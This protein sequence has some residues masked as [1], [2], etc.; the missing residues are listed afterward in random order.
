MGTILN[1][2]CQLIDNEI[3]TYRMHENDCS[4]LITL[5]S[6][7]EEKGELLIY[8]YS[9]YTDMKHDVNLQMHLEKSSQLWLKFFYFDIKL[10][11]INVYCEM[12]EEYIDEDADLY[13]YTNNS[14]KN[15]Q[16]TIL[17]HDSKV[18]ILEQGRS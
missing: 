4:A 12:I 13:F 9:N 16:A 18:S 6:F 7:F 5:E 15:N 1:T 2:L 11:D 17:L 14:V 8:T 3:N 10:E